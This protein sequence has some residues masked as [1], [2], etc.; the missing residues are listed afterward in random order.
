MRVVE[1]FV[2]GTPRPQGSKRHVG[3]GRMIES[4]AHLAGWRD[5]IYLTAKAEAGNALVFPAGAVRAH[6]GF[7]MPRPKA[8]PKIAP[9]AVK[10]PDLDKLIRAVFD[11]ITGTIVT[12]DSQIVHLT[13]SKMIAR[14]DEPTGVHI[15]I[16]GD[17]A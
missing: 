13:A 6:L 12:D 3:N 9:P 4:S 11:A 10:R 2:P 7:V 1:F 5:R 17:T 15:R 8:T 14:P 16:T